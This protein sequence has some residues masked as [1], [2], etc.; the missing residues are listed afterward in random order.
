[1]AS[2]I[3]VDTIQTAAGGTPTAAD[4]GLNVTGSVIQ[5]VTDVRD[6]AS[7]VTISATSY[8]S[9]GI[10]ISITPK[11]ASSKIIITYDVNMTFNQNTSASLAVARDSTVINAGPGSAYGHYWWSASSV[12]L[13]GPIVVMTVDEPNTTD[14]VNYDLY[15]KMWGSGTNAQA[16]HNS[17]AVSIT[18]ME[19]AG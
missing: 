1:M 3:K 7:S 4:L 8:T 11:Y 9:L 17:S 19:I 5:V 15:G 18:L 13:Y 10:G 16:P 12:N 2:I 14:Q 6:Y